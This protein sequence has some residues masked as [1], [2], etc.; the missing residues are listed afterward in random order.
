M[1][2]KVFSPVIP[3]LKVCSEEKSHFF[4]SADDDWMEGYICLWSCVTEC[5]TMSAFG[6]E[7]DDVEKTFFSN[8]ERPNMRK[9]GIIAW[10]F[11]APRIFDAISCPG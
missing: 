11:I 9:Y 1:S 3:K 8:L 2:F 4:P 6:F 10:E 7:A 5:W